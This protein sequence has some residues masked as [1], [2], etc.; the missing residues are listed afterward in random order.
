MSEGN[1]VMKKEEDEKCGSPKISQYLIADNEIGKPINDAI[2]HEK[3]A[4]HLADLVRDVETP[5]NIALYGPWGSGK[6]TI[7]LLLEEKLKSEKSVVFVRVDT[8]KYADLSLRRNFIKV[9]AKKL[10]G[11]SWA[12]KR[13]SNKI[14][15]KL[16]TA[17]KTTNTIRLSW[18]S[19][20]IAGLIFFCYFIFDDIL[21]ILQTISI[22]ALLTLTSSQVTRNVS[23]PKEEDE[24]EEIFENM[25]KGDMFDQLKTHITRKTTFERLVIF[26][27]ELDRCPAED[28]VKN[29]NAVRTFFDIEKC[30]IIIAA[31]R[32]VLETALEQESQQAI[33]IGN[34]DPYYSTGGAYLDKVFRYQIS[35]PPFWKN[36]GVEYAVKLVESGEDGLW[37]K[38]QK[39][40][41]KAILEILVP[42]YVV[43]PRR[44][45]NLL[46]SFALRYRLAENKGLLSGGSDSIKILARLTCLQVEF[47]NFANDM[48]KDSELPK[49]VLMLKEGRKDEMP[50][51]EGEALKIAREYA[52]NKR[53]TVKIISRSSSGDHSQA[54]EEIHRK[55]LIRYLSGT[56]NIGCPSFSLLYL[57][58]EFKTELGLRSLGA[59]NLFDLAKNNQVGD[60]SAELKE[61]NEKD[62]AKLSRHLVSR[63]SSDMELL[64]NSGNVVNTIFD[65]RG[66]LLYSEYVEAEDRAKFIRGIFMLAA[67]DT[68]VL[69]EGNNADQIWKLCEEVNTWESYFLRINIIEECSISIE[70]LTKKFKFLFDNIGFIFDASPDSALSISMR[71]LRF[72]SGS[73]FIRSIFNARKSDLV[74]MLPQVL[75]TVADEENLATVR[76]ILRKIASVSLGYDRDIVEVILSCLVQ[77]DFHKS[78]DAIDNILLSGF[79]S[80]N[81]QVLSY[82][83]KN[84]LKISPSRQAA[85]LRHILANSDNEIYSDLL[86]TLYA[87]FM[88]DLEQIKRSDFSEIEKLI[89]GFIHVIP[90]KK[91]V[92]A[93]R[94]IVEWVHSNNYDQDNLSRTNIFR[95]YGMILGKRGIVGSFAHAG[96]LMKRVSFAISDTKKGLM[97]GAELDDLLK[98]DLAE[99][100]FDIVDKNFTREQIEKLL[101]Q[102]MRCEMLDI[103]SRFTFISII[104]KAISKDSSL[105]EDPGA[106]PSVDDINAQ[107]RL[108]GGLAVKPALVWLRKYNSPE[109]S[110]KIFNT[111]FTKNL[112]DRSGF[113][114]SLY[115]DWNSKEMTIFW[116]E[117]FRYVSSHPQDIDVVRAFALDQVSDDDEDALVNWL[118]STFSSYKNVESRELIVKLWESANIVDYSDRIKGNILIPLLEQHLNADSSDIPAV[119]L[120][121]S[122]VERLLPKGFV[123]N[124]LELQ[125]YFKR[126][127]DKTPSL[128]MPIERIAQSLG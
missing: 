118:I 84:V 25:I 26:V 32:N 101:Y 2:G 27:D 97:S 79:A 105:Y 121:I 6:T 9:I 103:S 57:D 1:S 125:N 89:Y 115:R 83:F 51:V 58:P 34:E 92:E 12:E 78:E 111:L 42:D 33:P 108:Y 88:T 73:T 124:D 3:I 4:E 22:A 17:S 10:Y 77:I 94:R 37:G 128:W 95:W 56:R 117:C 8:F 109:V 29:L 113:A 102:L 55:R 120:G 91:I 87:D 107:L 23:S 47:P 13:K 86:V 16:D 5:T 66:D 75:F 50:E 59:E 71:M 99:D 41:R 35:I 67:Q 76:N 123:D 116:T 11:G 45:K 69:L 90:D 19:L 14:K 122:V 127:L 54:I 43:S 119:L 39:E 46:N 24:F 52:E 61:L 60:F 21:A 96:A 80:D 64:R 68:S 70:L 53:S 112:L 40:Y 28:M 18:R 85:W 36:Q 98:E 65:F 72:Q 31:D 81:P 93:K 49:H 38:F 114:D 30:V 110:A 100:E 15:R 20:F 106:L 7:G 44:V 104:S 82:V 126:V 48:L 62:C 74:D 63:I